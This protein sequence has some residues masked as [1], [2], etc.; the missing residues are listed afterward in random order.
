MSNVKLTVSLKTLWGANAWPFGAASENLHEP[1]FWQKT[2]ESLEQLLG[3]KTSGILT[4]PNGV[5][6]SRMIQALVERLPE[7]S[8]RS[9]L[10]TH[11]TLS[12][13]DISRYLCRSQGLAAAQR[14]SDN[15]LALRQYWRQLHPVWPVVIYEEAQNLSTL[16]LE[17]LRLLTC[18]RYDTQPPFSLI[19]TGDDSLLP[20]L[21]MGVNRPLLSRLGFGL[22]ISPWPPEE[23]AAYIAAR[24]KEVG[25]HDAVLDPQPRICWYNWPA[26]CRVSSI[27]WPNAPSRK[28]PFKM[29]ESSNR[30]ISRKPSRKYHGCFLPPADRCMPARRWTVVCRE[31]RAT[32]RGSRPERPQTV[33]PSRP[34]RPGTGGKARPSPLTTFHRLQFKSLPHLS[35]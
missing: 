33:M 12:S 11:A 9:I 16:A 15:V 10:L 35:R 23:L 4:G 34:D 14:R 29:P 32:C 28:P 24:L 5:G 25:I 30:N 27:I 17:E 2:L 8:Y 21:Q 1:A 18:D 6:K 13:G 3:V 26:V 19:L 7:K 20:R 31:D 22:E